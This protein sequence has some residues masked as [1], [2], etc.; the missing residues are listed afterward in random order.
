M[1]KT[2]SMIHRKAGIDRAELFRVWER[3]HAPNV[4]RAYEPVRYVITHFD[5][6]PDGS[7]PPYDGMVELTYRDQAHLDR[8]GL[9]RKDF[10]AADGFRERMLDW[11]SFV[12]ARVTPHVIADGPLAEA[13][14]KRVV[15]VRRAEHVS[16]A[17]Y[18]QHLL[19]ISRAQYR[20]G[21]RA[22]AGLPA[23]RD[24]HGRSSRCPV[25]RGGTLLLAL[26][27]GDGGGADRDEGR[28]HRGSQ[29]PGRDHRIGRSGSGDRG[30]IGA[31]RPFGPLHNVRRADDKGHDTPDAFGL[32][33]RPRRVRREFRQVPG[34]ISRPG[35]VVEGPKPRAPR[36]GT[37]Q[38]A[39]G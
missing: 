33:R 34:A 37:E 39:R 4:V 21:H 1:P 17:D 14:A 29:C 36:R 25:R 38:S 23:V 2:L 35:G 24:R 22:D 3:E 30:L 27:R 5:A 12:A 19:E 13:K 11:D 15:V 8:V 16:W 28:R 10:Q 7:D 18:R 9:L 26:C 20:R 6:L 32:R 31:T